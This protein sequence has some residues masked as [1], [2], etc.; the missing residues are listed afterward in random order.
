MVNTSETDYPTKM[1]LLTEKSHSL[2]EIVDARKSYKPPKISATCYSARRP[3]FYILNAF[4]LIFMITGIS[5]AVFSI[6]VKTPHFRLQTTYTL[7]LTAISL[8]WVILNRS[9]PSISYLTS[10]DIYQ[11]ACFTFICGLATWHALAASFWEVSLA[12]ELD[13]IMSIIFASLLVV[14]HVVFLVWVYTYNKKRRLLK[15]DEERYYEKYK[16]HFIP[17]EKI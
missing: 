6:N 10:L 15:K 14:L 17:H 9:I 12:N 2:N 5:L 16:D 8:K 13:E 7:L 11:I 1:K 4:F 3:G